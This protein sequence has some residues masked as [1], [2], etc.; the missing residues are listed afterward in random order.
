MNKTLKK[1]IAVTL[2]T[3]T[4]VS[5]FLL[6][7]SA[8]EVTATAPSTVIK[9]DLN[10][11]PDMASLP[12][13]TNSKIVE[14]NKVYYDDGVFGYYPYV[15]MRFCMSSDSLYFISGYYDSN[16]NESYVSL[17]L[18]SNDEIYEAEY[19]YGNSYYKDT[20]KKVASDKYNSSSS[21]SNN[22]TFFVK[23]TTFKYTLVYSMKWDRGQAYEDFFVNSNFNPLVGNYLINSPL[24]S[25]NTV[26][27]SG[28]SGKY[29]SY[30]FTYSEYPISF[31]KSSSDKSNY[32]KSWSGTSGAEYNNYWSLD[33]P[34][35]HILQ[36]ENLNTSLDS[37]KIISEINSNND[38]NA[39]EIVK[40]I[41]E[42]VTEI[43]NAGSDLPELS[44]DN[45]WM[46][47][48]LTK[49]NGWLDALDDFNDQMDDNLADNEENMQNASDFINGF[50]DILPSGVIAALSLILVIIVVV[51]IVGR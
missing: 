13:G 31:Y 20:F 48:A 7:A 39:T 45:D 38:K 17:F 9:A 28:S 49:V 11:Y 19:S 21:Y 32:L 30:Y 8:L 6:P 37:D 44:T 4:L 35:L 2:V 29:F 12:Y 23:S 16:Y 47:E 40:A 33:N 42:A 50:F 46:N 36:Y 51:K 18:F 15:T 24:L 25:A 41:G 14:T 10:N 5:C 27:V 1:L 26:T 43:I 22:S 3:A 34:F